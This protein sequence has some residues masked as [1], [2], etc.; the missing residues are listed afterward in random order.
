MKIKI[1]QFSALCVASVNLMCISSPVVG[2][3][4]TSGPTEKAC[5]ESGL[6]HLSSWIIS[7]D[8]LLCSTGGIDLGRQHG[9]GKTV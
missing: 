8:H 9:T 4:V 7:W 5:V 2:V 6:V 1:T 3:A